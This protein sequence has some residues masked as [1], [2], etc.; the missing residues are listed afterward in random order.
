M[1]FERIA[2]QRLKQ[3]VEDGE[4][5]N[6]PNAGKPL[7]LDEYFSWPEALRLAYSVLKNA[8]CVPIEVELLKE[9]ARLESALTSTDDPA[10]AASLKRRIIG[11]RIELAIKLERA[12]T[13]G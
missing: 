6:L 10:A 4:F 3:A 7:D 1:A 2:E 9:I 5:D 12:R 11:R 8:N 13:R